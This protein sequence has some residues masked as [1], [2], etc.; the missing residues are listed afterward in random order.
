MQQEHKLNHIEIYEKTMKNLDTCY[1]VRGLMKQFYSMNLEK[2]NEAL[3]LI[4]E[5]IDSKTND[6]MNY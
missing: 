2:A 4:K 3:N 6:F 1:E 5:M